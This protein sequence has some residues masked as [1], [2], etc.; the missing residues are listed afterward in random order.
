M[1]GCL[2]GP[3]GDASPGDESPKSPTDS[4]DNDQDDPGSGPSG[5]NSSTEEA[6]GAPAD[7]WN[8]TDRLTLA[9]WNSTAPAG[10]SAGV[11]GVAA[12][13]GGPK[14][15]RTDNLLLPETTRLDVTVNL[16]GTSSG[17]QV[18]Y[19]PNSTGANYSRAESNISWLPTVT[20]GQE[21]QAVDVPAA[22]TENSTQAWAFYYRYDGGQ[23]NLCSTGLHQGSARILVEA[24]KG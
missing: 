12:C 11:Q 23:E 24:V 6:G 8:G 9:R 21:T 1:S 16:N 22:Q 5:E 4:S 20:G 19:T 17:I 2:T 15:E 3:P 18:G 7:T 10:V 14:I 13:T